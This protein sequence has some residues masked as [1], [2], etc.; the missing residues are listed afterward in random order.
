MSAK[1]TPTVANNIL[2]AK[3]EFPKNMLKQASVT[4]PKLINIA[5]L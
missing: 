5:F 1:E 3:K 2:A 4:N